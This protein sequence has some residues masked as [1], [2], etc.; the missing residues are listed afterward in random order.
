MQAS[1]VASIQGMDPF[2]M[3]CQLKHTQCKEDPEQSLQISEMLSL[4][5]RLRFPYPNQILQIMIPTMMASFLVT[6]NA[7]AK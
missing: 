5:R 1:V 4:V 3:P 7:C 6:L 2:C